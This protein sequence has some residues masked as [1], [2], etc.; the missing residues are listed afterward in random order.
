MP[1]SD[2]V[3]TGDGE[4]VGDGDRSSASNEGITQDGQRDTTNSSWG[5]RN[6]WH[7]WPPSTTTPTGVAEISLLMQRVRWS[8]MIWIDWFLRDGRAGSRLFPW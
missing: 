3:D 2:A 8:M 4:S 1:T 5:R 6:S 7:V